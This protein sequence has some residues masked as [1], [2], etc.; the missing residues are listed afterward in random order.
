ML[1]EIAT[2]NLTESS[3]Q[4]VLYCILALSVFIWKWKLCPNDN[5]MGV[6][7]VLVVAVVTVKVPTAVR[8]P[9]HN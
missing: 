1:S 4:Y 7:L 9:S 6:T 8:V 5:V 3:I 2:T